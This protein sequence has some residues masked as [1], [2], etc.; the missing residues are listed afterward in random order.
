MS[1]KA[2]DPELEIAERPT[3]L[4]PLFGLCLVVACG[5]FVVS[6]PKAPKSSSMHTHTLDSTWWY[7]RSAC[8]LLDRKFATIKF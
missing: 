3:L 1:L 7:T 8:L 6:D 5:D 2:G 4:S